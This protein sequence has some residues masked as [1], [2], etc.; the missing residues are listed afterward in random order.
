MALSEKANKMFEPQIH[1]QAAVQE[2]ADLISSAIDANQPI[3]SEVVVGTVTYR[4]S[5][6]FSKVKQYTDIDAF[7]TDLE[8]KFVTRDPNTDH[9]TAINFSAEQEAQIRKALAPQKLA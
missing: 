4:L 9:T 2:V 7:I 5:E 3:P 6:I 1:V 8:Q